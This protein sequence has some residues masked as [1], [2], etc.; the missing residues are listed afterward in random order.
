MKKRAIELEQPKQSLD[1]KNAASVFL[2][3]SFICAAFLFAL[4]V[5]DVLDIGQLL[6]FEKPGD[7]LLWTAAITLALVGYGIVLTV[8]LPSST[9]D[10]GNKAYQEGSLA[11]ITAV[12]LAGAL[13][14]EL[15]F[16]GLLQNLFFLWTDSSWGA[17]LLATVVFLL[18][19]V[20]YFKKPLMLLN[21]SLPGIALGW[22]YFKTDN[23]LVPTVIHFIMNY[24][25]TLLF[26]YKMIAMKD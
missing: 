23:L 2:L 19:H 12:M 16:R 24:V 3:F 18:F 20:Q 14:E 26:K 17:I 22:V 10:E 5:L 4:A 15:F 6:S 7:L 13:F 11:S 1:Q 8:L 9:V 21:V 25:I